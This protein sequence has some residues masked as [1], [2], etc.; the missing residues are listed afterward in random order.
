MKKKK[1]K[2]RL[3]QPRKFSKPQLTET[4]S[5]LLWFVR[6]TTDHMAQYAKM[7]DLNTV[8]CLPNTPI[9]SNV[10]F[11]VKEAGYA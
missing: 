1:S 11:H 5:N 7:H 6:F 2:L 8:C 4:F 10:W 3:K 9:Q